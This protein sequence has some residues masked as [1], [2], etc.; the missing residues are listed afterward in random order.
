MAR[1]ILNTRAGRPS[2]LVSDSLQVP[3]KYGR[4]TVVDR[5][6]VAAAHAAFKQ[7]IVWTINDRDEMRTLL[8]MGVDGIITDRIDLLRSV[9]EERQSGG[10]WND[11]GRRG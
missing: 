9:M 6:T 2:R 4:I 7:L 3:V 8:N 11:G 5:K 10:P 1:F